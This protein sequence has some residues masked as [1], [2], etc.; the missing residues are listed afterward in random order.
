MSLQE[1]KTEK[2]RVT[3]NLQSEQEDLLNIWT[4]LPLAFFQ[5]TAKQEEKQLNTFYLHPQAFVYVTV[6][7]L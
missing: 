5:Y 4:P 7:S 2:K 6:N 3:T 1:E